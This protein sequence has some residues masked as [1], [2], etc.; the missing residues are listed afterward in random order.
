M[1]SCGKGRWFQQTG[2]KELGPRT[3]RALAIAFR[4]VLQANE[5]DRCARGL[6]LISECYSW[7]SVRKSHTSKIP[8]LNT[9]GY[10]PE[11]R[12]TWRARRNPSA[13][14]AETEKERGVYDGVKNDWSLQTPLYA[15]HNLLIRQ[16]NQN[17]L[18][19]EEIKYSQ[20]SKITK[21]LH[22][23]NQTCLREMSAGESLASLD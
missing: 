7:R 17:F 8:S 22:S 20:S 21:Y 4:G 11:I 12:L 5:C 16:A 2:L 9:A 10:H 14:C 15:L 18:E 13:R 1:S 3:T 6:R 23:R 19:N